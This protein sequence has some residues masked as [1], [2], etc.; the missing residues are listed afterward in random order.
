[1][2]LH[3]GLSRDKF[4]RISVCS[5]A[6]KIWD[7]L[8]VTYEET[9]KVKE[10]KINLLVTQY[11]VFKIDES[12]IIAHIYSRFIHLEYFI[13][14]DEEIYLDF[15]HPESPFICNFQLIPNLFG[16]GAHADSIKLISR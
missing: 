14:G 5:T 13:L 16:S 11:E 15:L 1:M 2:I 8:E 7:K 6:K 3:C 12:E 4:N 10:T 9:S